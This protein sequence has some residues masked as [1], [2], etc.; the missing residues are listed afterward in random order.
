MVINTY[1]DRVNFCTLSAESFLSVEKRIYSTLIDVFFPFCAVLQ[2]L[3]DG[4]LLSRS[5]LWP[6]RILNTYSARRNC[7]I[8]TGADDPTQS[9]NTIEITTQT[10]TRVLPIRKKIERHSSLSRCPWW[11]RRCR[12]RRRG[13]GG[14]YHGEAGEELVV[15]QR[16]V[17]VLV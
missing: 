2:C 7:V 14:V 4:E 9:T 5:T 3:G 11:R 6:Y 10:S 12:R 17:S 13:L 1:I 16:P 8:I 15:R